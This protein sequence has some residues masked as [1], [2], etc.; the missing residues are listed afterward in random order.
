M[1]GTFREEEPKIGAGSK[2]AQKESRGAVEIELSP[3]SRAPLD[4]QSVATGL[5]AIWLLLEEAAVLVSVP[6]VDEIDVAV[7]GALSI[8]LPLTAEQKDPTLN[9]LPTVQVAVSPPTFW[10]TRIPL[11][12][13]VIQ[14]SSCPA[15]RWGPQTVTLTAF[16]MVRVW[17][18]TALKS[19]G[20]QLVAPKVVHTV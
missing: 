7:S 14:A 20:C 1:N 15:C 17:W 11:L 18:C 3:L 16:V 9:S 6:L 8:E 10:N 19:S 5:G 2:K 4:Q 12:S 13:A